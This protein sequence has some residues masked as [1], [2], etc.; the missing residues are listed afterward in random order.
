[1]DPAEDHPLPVF[2]RIEGGNGQQEVRTVLIDG[3]PW[4]VAKG[5]CEV[6]G[7]EEAHVAVRS[8]AVCRALAC[9][10]LQ[11]TEFPLFCGLALGRGENTK[12]P[13]ISVLRLLAPES[14]T[15]C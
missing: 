7:L 11:I 9:Q 15:A 10:V 1:M 14:P 13:K 3:E 12:T 2:L 6:L 8:L 5:V 4:F